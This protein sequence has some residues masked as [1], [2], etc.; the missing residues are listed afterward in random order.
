MALIQGSP[1]LDDDLSSAVS[2]DEIQGLGGNDVLAANA[3][4][5]TLDGGPG[6][7]QLFSF[8]GDATLIGGPGD[9][10]LFSLGTNDTASY[11]F[12]L[13]KEPGE[14]ETF[15]FTDW[16]S[17]KYGKDFGDELPD[18]ERGHDH[19]HHGK[20]DHHHGKN[21]HH[22]G[23][24]DHHHGKNDHH[25]GKNDHHHGKNDHHHGKNDHHHGKNDHH[26]GKNDHHHGK[27]DHHHG[28]NDH[29]HGK[30][31][32]HHG[33]NDHHYGKSDHH[34][35]KHDGCDDHQLQ[36]WGLSQSFFSKN[37]SEWLREVVVPDLEAQLQAQ[38]LTLDTNGDGRIDVSLN[39]KDPDGTP[40]IEGLSDG[41]LS[42]IFGDRD[43][44]ALRHG[45]HGHD[46][47]YSN[48]YT[49]STGEGETTIAS[50]DGFDTIVNF[51]FGED[52]LEFKG[53]GSDFTLDQF[54]SVFEKTESDENGD[55][56]LDTVLGLADG[57]WGVTLLSESG[58]TL[59]EFYDT[60]VFS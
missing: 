39:Q 5:I 18:F 19:H 49:S 27:N 55:N 15:K 56:V 37:Y 44:V 12:T 54:T 1:D 30:N 34:H 51:T 60:S 3:A 48:S 2:G 8:I 36:Q 32:H 50:D 35:H 20:N 6:D 24:N 38:G 47:W 31:D 57:T 28:K 13:N 43:E 17:E 14:A 26:H 21:D 9:D 42:A 11:L 10:L 53:L 45:H 25:H 59:D 16:L 58:H 46:R 23:K 22:H 52:K 33:K 7:D 41:E 29:H 4:G 40:R